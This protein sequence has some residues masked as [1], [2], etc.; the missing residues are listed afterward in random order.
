M[1]TNTTFAA[2]ERQ[3]RAA[4]RWLILGG[5]LLLVAVAVFAVAKSK[6]FKKP[7]NPVSPTPLTVK[8]DPP[9]PL[10]DAEQAALLTTSQQRV[11]PICSLLDHIS[12][13]HRSGFVEHYGADVRERRHRPIALDR[14]VLHVGADQAWLLWWPEHTPP[15]ADAEMLEVAFAGAAPAHGLLTVGLL[16]TSGETFL[17]GHDFGDAPAAASI[18]PLPFF[19]EE[20]VK[21]LDTTPSAHAL[22]L[23]DGRLRAPLPETLRALLRQG[24]DRAVRCWFVRIAGARDTDV[25]FDRISL[26]RPAA[27]TPAPTVTLAGI[28]RGATAQSV[29]AVLESGQVRQQ[30]VSV[31][32]RFT[33]PGIPADMPVSLRVEYLKQ[34]YYVTLGRWFVPGGDRTD[35][36]VDCSPSYVNADGHKPDPKQRIVNAVSK[37]GYSEMYAVHARQLWNGAED[38]PQQYAGLNFSNNLG[39]FDR[40]RFYDNPD[41]CFR[42]VHLGSSHAVAS[43]VRACD[44]YNILMEAELGVRLGR[45]VEVVSLGRNNGDVAA[46]YIR[47]RDFA[48]KFRPNVILLE[49]GSFLMMQIHPELLRRMHGYDAAHTH[50]DNFY[51]DDKGVLTYRPMCAEWPLHVGKADT[52]ELVAG[53]PFYDTLRV[54]VAHMHPWGRESFKY[55]AD[56]L[57]YYRAQYPG[58]KIFLHTA[59]DQAQANGKYGRSTKLA[60]GTVIPI[61]VEVFLKNMDEFCTREGAVCINP[62]LPQ[63]FNRPDTLLTFA[64]DGHY[65]PRGHQWLARGLS[66]GLVEV[67][68]HP[69]VMGGTVP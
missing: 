14:T 62:P 17:F 2:K 46:N 45:P 30:P 12:L 61:G 18:A 56:I 35:L 33:L 11:R 47:V 26:L 50:L 57:R 69:R 13:Y 27:E 48:V 66:A 16:L 44:R 41:H 38:Y 3:R 68:A 53:V 1:A 23:V 51:Y 22:G 39:H 67:I 63:G 52:S 21:A 28:V 58:Q 34:D 24:G 5:A 55:L 8:I 4:R 49:H 15:V 29:V 60:D 7:Q 43:Q 32:G 65:C 36:M 6:L 9:P 64:N 10:S 19:P 42:V 54:P 31:D 40:D 37:P 20:V 25:A 59:L